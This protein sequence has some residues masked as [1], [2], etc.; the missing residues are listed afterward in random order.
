VRKGLR[1]F[2]IIATSQMLPNLVIASIA[3][4]NSPGIILESTSSFLVWMEEY[5]RIKASR[6]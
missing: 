5:P 1:D 3:P 4:R 2:G 6:A